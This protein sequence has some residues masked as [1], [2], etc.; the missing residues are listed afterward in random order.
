MKKLLIIAISGLF[1]S[2][3][4]TLETFTGKG[5]EINDGALTGAEFVICQGAS[6]GSIRRHYGTA[7]GARVWKELC[8]SIDDFNPV[9]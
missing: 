3:C 4:A 5:A 9:N 1:M 8:N 7:E 2:G 6:I